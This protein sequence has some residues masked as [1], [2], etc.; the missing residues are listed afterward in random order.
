LPQIRK[1]L[2]IGVVGWDNVPAG[3]GVYSDY[4]ATVVAEAQRLEKLV[5]NE[6]DEDED[7]DL[8]G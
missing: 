1:R 6:D 3:Q 8:V 2:A 4:I 5:H 7:E